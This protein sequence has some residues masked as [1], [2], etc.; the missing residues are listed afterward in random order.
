MFKRTDK[1]APSS[2]ILEVVSVDGAQTLAMVEFFESVLR[3]GNLVLGKVVQ[4]LEARLPIS[5]DNLPNDD[6][7]IGGGIIVAMIYRCTSG[8]VPPW[9]IEYVPGLFHALFECCRQDN[10]YFQSILL[11]GAEMRLRDGMKFGS[12]TN[13]L[14]GYYYDTM[15][16][17]GKEEFV[18]RMK[19]VTESTNHDKWRKLKV[20]VK[21]VC[22]GKKK[23]SDFN[24]KPQYTIWN[25]DRI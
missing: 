5:P 16:P 8:S 15:R 17:K 24:L 4:K 10:G 20:L 23:A 2:D 7:M 3:F 25:C 19:E 21:S 18:K 14:A 6:S 12:V 13:T 9:A 11:L 22:G 1:Q